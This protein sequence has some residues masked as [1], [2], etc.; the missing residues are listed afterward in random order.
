VLVWYAVTFLV[1]VIELLVALLFL[2][3]LGLGLGLGYG[4]GRR[5]EKQKKKEEASQDRSKKKKKKKTT[6]W[7]VCV[8]RGAC[9]MDL[10]GAF[11][12]VLP[13]SSSFLENHERMWRKCL[14]RVLAPHVCRVEHRGWVDQQYI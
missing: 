10:S 14:R 6:A 1:V 9:A 3:A 2:V 8:V 11:V 4:R 7:C 12:L 5:Q 13:T